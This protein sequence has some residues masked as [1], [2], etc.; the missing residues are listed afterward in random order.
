MTKAQLVFLLGMNGNGT[1]E[2]PSSI[3]SLASLMVDSP[4]IDLSGTS[5]I[6]IF[7]AS[8]AKFGPTFSEFFSICYLNCLIAFSVFVEGVESGS[9][10]LVFGKL[11][12]LLFLIPILGVIIAF[13]TLLTP[14]TGQ[15][16]SPERT[17]LSNASA[18]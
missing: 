15:H 2:I 12:L 11:D 16:R 13:E 7:R 14:H 17:S 3:N 18:D 6:C 5:P 9:S 1:T 8:D 10:L 4:Y